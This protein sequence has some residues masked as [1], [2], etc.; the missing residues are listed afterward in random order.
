MI[1]PARKETTGVKAGGTRAP[2]AAPRHAAAVGVRSRPAV[3]PTQNPQWER[4]AL[5]RTTAGVPAAQAR[6]AVGR[7]D[8]PLEREADAA[9]QRLLQMPDPAAPP[10]TTAPSPPT[11]RRVCDDCAR[12]DETMRRR[13]PDGD[14]PGVDPAGGAA[15]RPRRPERARTALGPRGPG[16]L[17]APARPGPG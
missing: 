8:D 16:L 7:T 11:V 2:V 15:G 14:A 9:A 12:E 13:T 17:R 6:L 4:L 5:R 1:A 10:M 3:L